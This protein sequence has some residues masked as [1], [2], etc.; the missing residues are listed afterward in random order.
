MKEIE[1]TDGLRLKIAY[2]IAKGMEYLHSLT[3]KTIHRDLRS[4]NVLVSSVNKERDKCH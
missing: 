1:F 4:L 2:D 3:P